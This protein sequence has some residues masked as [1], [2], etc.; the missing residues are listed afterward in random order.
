MGVVRSLGG[1][2][3]SPAVWCALS[4]NLTILVTYQYAMKLKITALRYVFHEFGKQVSGIYHISLW[5]G[6]SHG[7]LSSFVQNKKMPY[8]GS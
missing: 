6:D 5:I 2:I 3:P 8:D 4:R 7:E 1:V